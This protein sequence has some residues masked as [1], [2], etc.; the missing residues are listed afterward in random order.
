MAILNYS[1]GLLGG[2]LI[3]LSTIGL[4][5]S[6]G[7]RAGISGL[8]GGSMYPHAERTDWGWRIAF[9]GGLGASGAFVHNL[10]PSLVSSP[11]RSIL[12]LGIAGLL[13]G[14]GARLGGGCTSGHGICGIGSGSVRSIIATLTFILVGVLTVFATRQL[15]EL[16]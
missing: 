14:A 11:L 3:G 15:L 4:L 8:L 9:L 16:C 12:V 13:V 2:A 5:Y 1:L 6:H 7:Q 10:F